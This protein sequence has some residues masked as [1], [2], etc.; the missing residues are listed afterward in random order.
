VGDALIS[1][2]KLVDTLHESRSGE[3][4]FAE[5]LVEAGVASPSVGLVLDAVPGRPVPL[6]VR[7]SAV[8][9]AYDLTSMRVMESNGKPVMFKVRV[10]E[11][12]VAAGAGGD[13]MSHSTWG[14]KT[15][16]PFV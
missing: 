4:R 8:C 16:T 10:E 14:G 6:P 3:A 12:V 1:G 15:E 9:V 2:H 11:A 5:A 13:A 7:P